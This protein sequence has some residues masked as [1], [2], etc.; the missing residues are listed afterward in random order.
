MRMI[1]GKRVMRHGLP[2]KALRDAQY[3]RK[4]AEML[5]R[6]SRCSAHIFFVAADN[7][8]RPS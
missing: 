7:L 5:A 3:R 8:F 4:P 2:C 1:I 6:R